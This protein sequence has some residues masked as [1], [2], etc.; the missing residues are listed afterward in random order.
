MKLS[1]IILSL[2]LVACN[3]GGGG[4]GNSSTETLIP[5]LGIW[6]VCEN[7]DGNED[8]T[9]DSSL[10]SILTIAEDSSSLIQTNFTG[11]N[12]VG[13]SE[14]Y[15]YSNT[16]SY[17][18]SGNTYSTVLKS[19]TYVSLKASDVTWNNANLWCGLNNWVLNVPQNTLGR[20]CGGVTS[21]Y[22]DV[23]SFTV[24]RSGN[25]LTI[26]QLT[27]TLAI[28]TDFTPAGLTLP[29]GSFAYSDGATIAIFASFN[30]GSYSV[31]RYD[32]A[33]KVYYTETGTYTS[34]NNVVNF[35][36]TGSSP[37]GCASGSA[38]RRFTTGSLGL[39]ME[40]SEIDLILFAQKVSYSESNFRTAFLGGGFSVGCF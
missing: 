39:T 29:N 19:D 26:D 3:G 1:L 38:S 12:C 36:V 11:I 5:H 25:S 24:V 8:G 31:Y 4:G 34:G 32:L 40:F 21:S 10:Q 18:R 37:A 35:T 30:S 6:A 28:G 20:N 27:Y 16:A 22:G 15:R 13:G 9:N 14:E 2:S 7:Y 17:T 33:S 23:Q